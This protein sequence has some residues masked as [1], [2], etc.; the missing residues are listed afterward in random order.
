M[1][2]GALGLGAGFLGWRGNRAGWEARQPAWCGGLRGTTNQHDLGSSP[3]CGA[4]P[5]Q[6]HPPTRPTNQPNPPCS[7]IHAG[8]G[9]AAYKDAVLG[10]GL[11]ASPGAAVGRI[12]F[13]A[14]EAE[15]WH[16]E[17]EKV[18]GGG[19]G[20]LA[21]GLRLGRAG[22]S[23]W[24]GGAPCRNRASLQGMHRQLPGAAAPAAQPNQ[25]LLLFPLALPC[26][27]GHPGAPGDLS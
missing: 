11:P 12:V 21:L 20:G 19:G 9:K 25:L 27:P 16:A 18:R 4:K 2:R 15:K 6:R 8:T 5:A 26:A 10:K 22:M 24:A 14:D 17:G 3:P 1:G 23:L 13:T 7:P